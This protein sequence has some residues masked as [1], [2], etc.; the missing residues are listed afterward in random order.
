MIVSLTWLVFGPV[1]ASAQLLVAKNYAMTPVVA[2]EPVEVTY[3]LYNQDEE[4]V[5]VGD[6]PWKIPGPPLISMLP[7]V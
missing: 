5:M 7:L 1:P 2:G 4:Y 3:E 6:G